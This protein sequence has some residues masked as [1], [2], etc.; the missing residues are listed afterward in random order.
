MKFVPPKLSLNNS[1]FPFTSLFTLTL[2]SGLTPYDPFKPV[3]NNVVFIPS[4]LYNLILS[5]E[6]FSP[7]LIKYPFKLP[8]RFALSEVR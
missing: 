1:Q 2:N 5:V 8:L 4:C 7:T 3:A 6:P